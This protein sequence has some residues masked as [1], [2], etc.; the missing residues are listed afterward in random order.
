MMSHKIAYSHMRCV[1]GPAAM[2]LAGCNI[3]A[4]GELG[5]FC[6]LGLIAMGLIRT[7]C[8]IETAAPDI[9]G[10]TISMKDAQCFKER[11]VLLHCTAFV[12]TLCMDICMNA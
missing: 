8:T 2:V 11:K 3:T 9:L 4:L 7:A 6:E 10:T 5:A 1:V 12:I